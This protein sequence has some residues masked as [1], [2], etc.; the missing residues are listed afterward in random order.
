MVALRSAAS[1]FVHSECALPL[2][3][4]SYTRNN[5]NTGHKNLRC[6]PHCCGSH[7]PNSF[8]GISVIV[9]HDTKS[10]VV[11]YSRFEVAAEAQI[12]PAI[13]I[14]AR[15]HASFIQSDL[16]TP[17]QPL[18]GWMHGEPLAV[19]TE[20]VVRFEFNG[21]RQCWHYGWR[22][23]RFNCMTKHVLMVYVFEPT[24]DDE[25]ECVDVLSS[26]QFTVCSSRRSSK[27]STLDAPSS[28]PA[29]DEDDGK[30]NEIVSPPSY[31]VRRV[32]S[33]PAAPASQASKR[34]RLGSPT[35]A[36]REHAVLDALAFWD[37]C[38]STMTH[39]YAD[40]LPPV[41][42]VAQPGSPF[43]DAFMAVLHA[44][45][46]PEVVRWLRHHLLAPPAADLRVS[47]EQL[48]HMLYVQIN[49]ALGS[50]SLA[51]WLQLVQLDTDWRPTSTVAGWLPVYAAYV[52]SMQQA[53]WF[54]G[55]ALPGDLG[56]LNGTWRRESSVKHPS[57]VVATMLDRSSI[58]WTCTS[59]GPHTIQV[60]WTDALC[61]PWVTLHLEHDNLAMPQVQSQLLAPGGISSIG[62]AWI[63]CGTRAWREN[64]DETL[65]IEWYFWPKELGAPRK[66]MR[67]RFSL[68][69]SSSDRLMCQL[70]VEYSD[71]VPLVDPGD[72]V[73]RILLPA[74]WQVHQI[75]SQY[76][77]RTTPS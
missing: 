3:A 29:S 43:Y 53:Q 46:R 57:V 49:G 5:K 52:D 30:A 56:L 9:E 1:R 22:S 25:L 23:N 11:S 69:P 75:I 24:G 33:P 4:D 70:F 66:R 44:V 50:T 62:T 60:R 73:Q 20:G 77:G 6:F 37:L 59:L 32:H 17:E 61:G 7:R 72:M 2:F 54:S 58:H 21:N 76:Y 18:G 26:P 38:L 16:K 34:P 27:A 68:L 74:N 12:V 40:A 10:P 63:L 8:C 14:G 47:F 51:Q 28:L 71:A 31:V 36:D 42:S 39:S 65:V 19:E 48:L 15:V 45:M 64:Q 67:E 13:P 55:D 35:D 41:A